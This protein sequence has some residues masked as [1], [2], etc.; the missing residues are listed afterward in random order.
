[1]SQYLWTWLCP[2]HCLPPLCPL[3]THHVH[4]LSAPRRVWG[5]KLRHGLLLR[6]AGHAAVAGRGRTGGRLPPHGGAL[7][8]VHRAG[9]NAPPVSRPDRRGP[10]DQQRGPR[11]G[12]MMLG[13]MGWGLLVYRRLVVD[14]LSPGNTMFKTHES[15]ERVEMQSLSEVAK[16][17][18]SILQYVFID[19]YK[20]LSIIL[21]HLYARFSTCSY[22]LFPTI[23]HWDLTVRRMHCNKVNFNK[24]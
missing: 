4:S 2:S 14:F 7:L 22:I 5:G 1:M 10:R 20:C 24:K 9:P 15:G 6:A 11:S 19:C 18:C 21:S 12:W 23:F 13:Q 16:N 8:P 17:D 3:S